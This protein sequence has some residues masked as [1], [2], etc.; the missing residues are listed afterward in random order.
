MKP[1]SILAL[2]LVLPAAYAQT[3]PVET[4]ASRKPRLK[5]NGDLVIRNARILTATRGTIERGDIL[6]RNGKIVALGKVNAP[7]GTPEIDA[8]G[9]VVAPG[10]VDAHVHRGADTTNEG[11]DAIVAE[12]RILDVLNPDAKNV[13]Q[14]VASGETSALILH[15]SANPIGAESLVVKLKYGR[16]VNELPVKDAPRMIKFALGENVTRSGQTNSTR[17]PRTRMGVQSVYRRAFT[18]AREY[19][20]KWA[21]WEAKKP[22]ATEPQRDLRLE[23]LS[24]ILKRKVWVQC[25]SYRADEI[26]MMVRLSQEFGF[27]IGA[28]QHALES[29]KLAPELAKAGVP[30][31]IFMDDWAGKLELYDG[32]PY[33]ASILTRAGAL[34]SVNTDGTS[35]TTAIALDGAKAMRFGGLSEEQALRLVTINPAKQLGIDHRTGSIEVGKDADLVIWDGHPLSVYSRVNTTI[36]EGEVMFQRRDAHGVNA[37]ST[38]KPKITVAEY[39]PHPPVPAPSRV[40]AIVGGTVHPVSGPTLPSGTV[41]LRDGKVQAVGAKVAVP[42][43]AVVVDAKG[44]QVYPG[45]IDAGTTIGLTEFGQVGQATD[46]RELGSFQPD[47]VASTAVQAQSEH[48]PTTRTAGVTTVVT[49]PGGGTVP[50]HSSILNLGGFTSEQM[51]IVP[52]AGMAVNWPGGGGGFGDGHDHDESCMVQGDHVEQSYLDQLLGGAIQQPQRTTST[53]TELKNFFDRAA[54]YGRGHDAADLGLDAMQPVFRQQLPVHIRVRDAESIRSA[55]AFAKERKIKVVLVGA[56]DAWREAKLL[57]EA[58]IPV[59]ITPAGKTTLGANTTLNDWDPY[60]TPYATPALLKRAGVKFCFQSEGYAEAKDLPIRVGQSCA[61]GLSREDAV[62]ALTLSA[63]EILG[64]ANKVGSITP[65][66]LGNLVISDGDPFE[67]SAQI[68]YVFIEGKPIP[69]TS[70]FTRLRDQ[71][72]KRL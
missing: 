49:R 21:D 47:L 62:R 43:G 52:R 53:P 8:T 35:G 65:G 42:K 31:S 15:G 1:F 38:L 2:A 51:A 39:L 29:Y 32:N 5:T 57:A 64:V 44:M 34:A 40:Y 6:V 25:H 60:D 26:L 54:K 22:G 50:G 46:E 14:A 36:I 16:P 7:T 30:A 68:R 13:W 59:I 10:I 33:A 45:F 63:A 11:T 24:D 17:F 19:M 4:N 55:V 66:K 58:K 37:G 71:Y 12:G 56:P 3:A 61:Y 48:I 20:K 69:L 27:K 28:M 67:P 72:M 23:T 9:K 18:Q 41:I 70:K